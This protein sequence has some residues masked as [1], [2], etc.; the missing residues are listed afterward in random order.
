[1]FSA[2]AGTPLPK[3][4]LYAEL[5]LQLRGLVADEADA[6]ANMANCAALLFNSLPQL[7]WAG[8]YLLKGAELV[9]GPFQGRPA[10]VRIPLGQGVCGTAAEKRTA[11][12]VS[13]VSAYPGHITCDSASR[14]EIVLPL[15]S[16]GSLH[17]VM[18]LDSPELNR[19]DEDDEAGLENLAAIVAEKLG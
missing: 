14:S 10:C 5:A 18:D 3:N 19:F 1:M 7:N 17:G 8:F 12:R 16:R 11:L 2:T 4:E 9:L 13:D 15:L 6:I